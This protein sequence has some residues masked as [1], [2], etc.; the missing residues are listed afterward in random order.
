MEKDID[1]EN[2]V[3]GTRIPILVLDNRWQQLFPKEHRPPLIK[4]LEKNLMNALRKQSRLETELKELQKLKKKLMSEIMLNMNEVHSEEKEEKRKKKLDKSQ[5]LILDINNKIEKNLE[6]LDEMPRVIKE[7]NETLMIASVKICYEKMNTN[8]YD[9]RMIT[10]WIDNT[11]N[12]LKKQILIKQD[13]Q[14][15]NNKIYTYL[16]DILGP[17]YMEIFDETD[18]NVEKL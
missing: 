7:A 16:H 11:R 5:Q 17:R 6:E 14:D 1:F 2:I 4:K 15:E 18:G 3:K 8:A 9:I 10:E 12:E 13:K